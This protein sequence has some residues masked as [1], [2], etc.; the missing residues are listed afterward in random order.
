MEI[1]NSDTG[2]IRQIMKEKINNA[3]K[4]KITKVDENGRNSR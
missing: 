2:S 1:L 4:N 3:T